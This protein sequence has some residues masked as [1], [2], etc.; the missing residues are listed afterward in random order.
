MM[1]SSF[2][3]YVVQKALK[4][5]VN[6]NKTKLV[7]TILNQVDKLNEKKLINKWK[8]IVNDSLVKNYILGDINEGMMMSPNNSFVS[9]NSNLS[10]VSFTNNFNSMNFK[11]NC[12]FLFV[13]N[14]SFN[15][16][17]SGSS[18]SFYNEEN[19]KY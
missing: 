10:N 5:A 11:N 7:E 15:M 13:Q 12:N 9:N 4:V 2:G 8:K 17:L 3:N 18:V 14:Q 16:S 1:K 6:E 19:K